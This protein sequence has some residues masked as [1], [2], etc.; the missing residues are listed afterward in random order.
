VDT[1]NKKAEVIVPDDQLSLSIGKAGQNVRLAAKLTG[2]HIDIKSQS[3]KKLQAQA[4]IAAAEAAAV[5]TQKTEMPGA[6]SAVEADKGL[7]RL[8]S[9]GEKLQMELINKGFDALEKIANASIEDLT[10]IPG[11]GTKKA[12][13]IIAAAKEIIS[14]S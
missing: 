5:A 3:D 8:P 10:R 11:I 6:E 9:V 7:T 14:K 4:S 1:P 13:K 2:W 12:E